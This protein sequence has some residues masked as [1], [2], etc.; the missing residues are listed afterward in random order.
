VACSP[1]AQGAPP[2]ASNAISQSSH[3]ETRYTRA[4]RWY[5]PAPGTGRTRLRVCTTRTICTA[6]TAR[7]RA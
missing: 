1:S 4:A 5:S 3:P 7:T 6:C 2:D